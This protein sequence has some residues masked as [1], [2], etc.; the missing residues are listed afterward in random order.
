MHPTLHMKKTRSS[1]V[2]II[3]D[4]LKPQDSKSPFINKIF[5]LVRAIPQGKVATYGQIAIL[6]GSPRASRIVGYA[7]AHSERH[8]PMP[9]HRVVFKDGSLCKGNVFGEGVQRKILEKEGVGFL[10]DGRVDM[11]EYWWDA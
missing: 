10:P 8:G 5:E 1:T 11:N 3:D 7:M 9:A 2:N 6:A 4:D